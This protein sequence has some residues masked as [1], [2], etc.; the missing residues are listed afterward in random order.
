MSEQKYRT[1]YGPG[2][3]VTRVPID[4]PKPEPKPEPKKKSDE[5]AGVGK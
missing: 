5:K 4:E 2:R 3:N 1:V